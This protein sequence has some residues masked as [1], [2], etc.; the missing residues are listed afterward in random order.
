MQN[1]TEKLYFHHISVYQDV[2]VF[3]SVC[4]LVCFFNLVAV[5]LGYGKNSGFSSD[6]RRKEGVVLRGQSVIH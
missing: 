5:H 4:L 2:M 3:L 1:S 6:Y